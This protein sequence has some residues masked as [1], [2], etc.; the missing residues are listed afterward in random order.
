MASRTTPSRH[1]EKYPLI[2][3]AYRVVAFCPLGRAV[4][5]YY[6]YTHDLAQMQLGIMLQEQKF[7]YCRIVLYDPEGKVE[8]QKKP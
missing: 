3:N 7:R 5:D 8:F 4:S 1:P 2:Q 6:L